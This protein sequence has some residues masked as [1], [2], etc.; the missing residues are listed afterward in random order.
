MQRSPQTFVEVGERV[1]ALL[2]AQRFPFRA[3]VMPS[4]RIGEIKVMLFGPNGSKWT[5]YEHDLMPA[6]RYDEV[7]WKP[8]GIVINYCFAPEIHSMAA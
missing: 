3:H 4:G 2:R 1:N 8:Q 7:L 6:L 5:E